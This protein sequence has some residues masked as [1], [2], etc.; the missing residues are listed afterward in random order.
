MIAIYI[1]TDLIRN[2]SPF[3]NKVLV[4]LVD[5]LKHLV[6]VLFVIDQYDLVARPQGPLF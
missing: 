3:Q 2:R 1:W 4:T 5:A 6:L